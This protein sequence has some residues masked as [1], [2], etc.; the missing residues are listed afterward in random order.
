MLGA[1]AVLT[2]TGFVVVLSWVAAP[3][4]LASQPVDVVSAVLTHVS[5]TSSLVNKVR[6]LLAS[7][8]LMVK[9]PLD[10][11]LM[12]HDCP[13]TNV[14]VTGMTIVCVNVPV[15]NCNLALATVSV[16]VPAAVIVVAY[17]SIVLFIVVLADTSLE[18]IV[19]AVAAAVYAREAK[20]F[21]P[22]V[23]TACDAVSEAILGAT[24]N[25]FTA[26][27]VCAN[28]SVA[29]VSVAVMFGTLRVC[30][31]VCAVARVNVVDAVLPTVLT[32]NLLVGVVVSVN[33]VVVVP[34]DLL[35]SVCVSVVPTNAPV[36]FVFTVNAAAPLPIITPVNV[37]APVPPFPTAN[38]PETCVVKPTL[39]YPGST[40][41]PPLSRTLPVAISG[42]RLRVVVVSAARM[43]PTAYTD[44]PVPPL[45]ANTGM[46]REIVPVE[47]MGL[48]G[49]AVSPVPTVIDVT[50]PVVGV[51]QDAAVAL[52]AV[53]TCPAVGGA[54]PVKTTE[55]PVVA[56]SEERIVLVVLV[57]V[58]LVSVSV[59]LRATM[60]SVVLGKDSVTA[61]LGGG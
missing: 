31:V 55:A 4:S 26:V 43:S 8:A 54:P 59:V 30:V 13:V 34:N 18:T 57:R 28:P 12:T 47:V 14:P 50:V 32:T 20:F 27:N 44:H 3:S 35:V 6:I 2:I 29:I 17:P 61:P 56:N 51:S 39:P 23:T 42:T 7:L 49:E 25:V 15:K 22:S 46:V 11:F 16:V 60:V 53:S 36:G 40:P 21:D 19:D 5:V 52:E 37:I 38:V 33:A 41:M 48:P 58:L 24:E 45:V 10:L 9:M 1:V